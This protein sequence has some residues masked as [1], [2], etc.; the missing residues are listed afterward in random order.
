MSDI[1]P[2]EMENGKEVKTVSGEVLIFQRLNSLGS[3]GINTLNNKEQ[4]LIS[5]AETPKKG[6][7]S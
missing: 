3:Q 5:A 2:G 7:S 1:E 4:K 6:L